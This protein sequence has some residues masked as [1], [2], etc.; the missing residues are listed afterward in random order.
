M[1]G[2]QHSY[3]LWLQGVGLDF[4]AKVELPASLSEKRNVHQSFLF[5]SLFFRLLARGRGFPGKVYCSADVPVQ[6]FVYRPASKVFSDIPRR[7]FTAL[8]PSSVMDKSKSEDAGVF[9]P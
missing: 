7:N 9:P 8:Q 1:K 4:C 2:S 3:P 6:R 5:P